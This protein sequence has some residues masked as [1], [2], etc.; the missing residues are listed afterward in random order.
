MKLRKAQLNFIV[1]TIAFV[2]MALLAATGI[3]VRYTLPPGSGHSQ[4]LWGM[5]RHGWGDIH[6]WI[7][8]TL[9]AMVVIHLALHWRW[10]LNMIRGDSPKTA[11]PRVAAAVAALILMAGV[12]AAPFLSVTETTGER[13]SESHEDPS[14]PFAENPVRGSMTLAEVAARAEMDPAA[15]LRELDWPADF[16]ID[17]RLGP[18]RREYGFNLDEVRA[19][20]EREVSPIHP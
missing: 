20:V 15:L 10:V 8:V 16:P 9:V 11:G 3:L 4:A 18:L 1:D 14:A 2:C 17:E 7:A 5:N 12:M 6:F 19:V 13:Q